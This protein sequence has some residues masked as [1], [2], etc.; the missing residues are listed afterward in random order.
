MQSTVYIFRLR[1]GGLVI[2]VDASGSRLPLDDALGYKP[3]D[4]KLLG[5]VPA[6]DLPAM[7]TSAKEVEPALIDHGYYSISSNQ[8]IDS[9]PFF[10][11]HPA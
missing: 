10:Q 1:D 7:I 5:P 4:W 6:A 9:H 3:G 11:R 2:T 8:I